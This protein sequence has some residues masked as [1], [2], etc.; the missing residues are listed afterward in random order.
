M[1]FP[2]P[3]CTKFFDH[4]VLEDHIETKHEE[5]SDWTLVQR[6][7][8]SKNTTTMNNCSS[9]SSSVV[10]SITISKKVKD[11]QKNSRTFSELAKNGRSPKVQERIE[12]HISVR[13]AGAAGAGSVA[14]GAVAAGAAGSVAAGSV[15]AGAVAGGASASS[16]SVLFPPV[17]P[18]PS[19]T[20]ISGPIIELPTVSVLQEVPLFISHSDALNTL[21]Q[22]SV[23]EDRELQ[24]ESSI[25]DPIQNVG[26]AP[27]EDVEL[28]SAQVVSRQITISKPEKVYTLEQKLK[29]KSV[30]LEGDLGKKYPN[31]ITRKLFACLGM[32]F[33]EE[34]NSNELF[35]TICNESTMF[36]TAYDAGQHCFGKST[37]I[38]KDVNTLSQFFCKAIGEPTWVSMLLGMP[39]ESQCEYFKT[40][41][42]EQKKELSRHLQRFRERRS[43]P[44]SVETRLQALKEAVGIDDVSTTATRVHNAFLDSLLRSLMAQGIGSAFFASNFQQL[45][46]SPFSFT[47][48]AADKR[49][50]IIVAE[51]IHQFRLDS[52]SATVVPIY[53]VSHDKGD[54]MGSNALVSILNYFEKVDGKLWLKTAVLDYTPVQTGLTGQNISTLLTPAMRRIVDK[55]GSQSIYQIMSD[56]TAAND[57]A[58]ECLKVDLGGITQVFRGRCVS[59]ILA[60]V[61]NKSNV[62]LK[63]RLDEI[64]VP[65]LEI[66][67]SDDGDRLWNELLKTVSIDHLKTNPETA[68]FANIAKLRK[69]SYSTIRWHSFYEVVAHT[70]VFGLLGKTPSSAPGDIAVPLK[71]L[72]SLLEQGNYCALSRAKLQTI[73]QDPGRTSKVLSAG[74]V[75]VEAFHLV[76]KATYF[77]EGDGLLSPIVAAVVND[78]LEDAERKIQSGTALDSSGWPMSTAILSSEYCVDR[79]KCPRIEL[80]TSHRNQAN[81]ALHWLCSEGN[82]NHLSPYEQLWAAC[83]GILPS[84]VTELVQ[85]AKAGQQATASRIIG[86]NGGDPVT[87]NIAAEVA[88]RFAIWKGYFTEAEWSDLPKEA[89]IVAAAPP[90][91]AG[92]DLV[93]W[94]NRRHLRAWP[95]LVILAVLTMV[96]NAFVE[97]V[98]ACLRSLFKTSATSMS[99]DRVLASLRLRLQGAH[100]PEEEEKNL[101]K[102]ST[103]VPQ[104]K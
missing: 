99:G 55:K 45:S 7:R 64:L 54:A 46:K 27:I 51:T 84:S 78:I 91:S 69:T 79:A 21:T 38:R 29:F 59:H 41:S 43:A 47:A 22:V 3:F 39:Y 34:A 37:K 93:D 18:H 61:G 85:E 28:S 19:V 80:V 97:R 30:P 26:E 66:W 35:C 36:G 6:S 33:S 102:R 32:F 8:R 48:S 63:E 65:M 56:S 96:N 104:W 62:K 10:K 14:A 20:Q 40:K 89:L 68:A 103:I 81:E 9:S 44:P 98:F 82:E 58:E 25:V 74:V 72:C 90:Y 77:L 49:I 2:C 75:Y 70:V 42:D 57:V 94:Y 52:T 101:M 15:A 24:S 16:S 67:G 71:E 31:S 88:K 60:L 53:T 5:E 13:A 92:S 4:D 86:N 17:D 87:V 12:Q 1:K 23:G 50:E 76:V 73:L 11:R 100:L 83:S 95:K